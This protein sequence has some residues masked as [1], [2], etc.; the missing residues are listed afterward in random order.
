MRAAGPTGYSRAAKFLSI[1]APGRLIKKG[2]V[3]PCIGDV[4]QNVTS[5]TPSIPHAY[6]EAAAGDMLG[7]LKNGDW[8]RIDLLKRSADVRLTE[9]EITQRNREMGIYKIPPAQTP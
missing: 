4:R 5:G 1:H 9:E 8:V 3:L 6:P 2:I 7:Y